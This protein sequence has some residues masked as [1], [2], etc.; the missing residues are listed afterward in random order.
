MTI[1]LQDAM[2]RSLELAAEAAAAGDHPYGAVLITADGQAVE[3]RN[4]VVTTSDPTAHAESMA[5][6]VAAGKWGIDLSGATMV[7][8]YE[9]CPMCCGAILEAGVAVLAIGQRRTVGAAP[10]GRYTVENLLELLDRPHALQVVTEVF[11]DEAAAF[12]ATVDATTEVA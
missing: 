2:K 7:A 5:I 11:G 10:L 1:S 4:R 6:R 3:E 9:P 8:S 12:Y